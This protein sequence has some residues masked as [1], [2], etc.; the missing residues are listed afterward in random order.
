[1]HLG[2]SQKKLFVEDI[3]FELTVYSVIVFSVFR[4]R[5]HRSYWAVNH[6]F[7]GFSSISLPSPLATTAV[8]ACHFARPAGNA[9]RVSVWMYFLPS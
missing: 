4:M 1:M 6:R 8:V 5:E 3:A 2:T 9:K 7:I